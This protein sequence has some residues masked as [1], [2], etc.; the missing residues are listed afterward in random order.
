MHLDFRNYKHKR[1]YQN[2]ASAGFK[3]CL[4]SQQDSDRSSDVIGGSIPT[5][6][7]FFGHLKC[8]AVHSSYRNFEGQNFHS[9]CGLSMKSLESLS[10]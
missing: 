7:A 5:A 6:K 2:P 3:V 10:Y 8:F 1:V 9:F 4:V